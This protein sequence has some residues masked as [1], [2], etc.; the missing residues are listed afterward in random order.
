[1][2]KFLTRVTETYRAD[3]EKEAAELIEAAKKN[4]AFILDKYSTT[5][6]DLKAKGEIV[7]TYY[8]VN[9]TKVFTDEKD[10]VYVIEPKYDYT[11]GSNNE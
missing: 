3:S 1:M 9:L 11:T 8:R 7:D 2:S 4:D 6:K 5:R 10:P